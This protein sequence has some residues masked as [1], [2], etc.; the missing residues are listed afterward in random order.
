MP[1]GALLR[2]AEFL[3][4]TGGRPHWRWPQVRIAREL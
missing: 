1:T 2:R 3:R 4:R